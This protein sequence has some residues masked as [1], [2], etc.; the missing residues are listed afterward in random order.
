MCGT[1][2]SIGNIFGQ[3]GSPEGIFQEAAPL[4]LTVSNL[5]MN[6]VFCWIA[7]PQLEVVA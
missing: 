4:I 7:K 1:V 3:G 5:M 2:E 6:D